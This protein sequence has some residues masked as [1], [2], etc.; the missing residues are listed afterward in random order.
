MYHNRKNRITDNIYILKCLFFEF[1]Y[2]RNKPNS[3]WINPVSMVENNAYPMKFCPGS[4]IV[5]PITSN[6]IGKPIANVFMCFRIFIILFIFKLS[7]KNES[8]S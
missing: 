3:T 7:E 6:I 1:L 2:K 5:N 4:F 8:L